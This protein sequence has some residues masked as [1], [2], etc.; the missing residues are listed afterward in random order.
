MVVSST[1][2]MKLLLMTATPMFNNVFEIHFLLNLLLMNDKRPVI[3]M[4]SI[5]KSDGSLADDA[6]KVLK[7]IVNAYV[8]FMR[9][10]NPNSFPL[11]LYPEGLDPNG[12]P[13]NRL[14]VENYPSI[15]LTKGL[16]ELTDTIQVKEEIKN[17]VKLPIVLSSAPADTSYNSILYALT[18]KLTDSGVGIQTRNELLQAS[19]CIFPDEEYDTDIPEQYIGSSGF[20]SVFE[21][22]SK[23]SVRAENAKWLLE[24]QLVKYSPKMATI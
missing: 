11:R 2:G 16:G 9:G 23:G 6:H 4:S 8:S 18:K 12:E 20:D 7:P 17:M 22:S 10:E 5:L 1:E 24:K 21:S 13:V 3:S 19:N 14:S 15:Q